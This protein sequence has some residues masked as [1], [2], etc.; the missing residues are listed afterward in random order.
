[1]LRDSARGQR[2]ISTPLRI[3]SVGKGLSAPATEAYHRD[4]QEPWDHV[5]PRRYATAIKALRAERQSYDYLWDGE[6]WLLSG[7]PLDESW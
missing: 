7:A 3:D 6:R 4:R 5:Q 1:M 2:P